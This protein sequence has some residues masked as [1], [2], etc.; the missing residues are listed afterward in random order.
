[1][2]NAAFEAAWDAWADTH[3]RPSLIV[4]GAT[5]I[6]R[7]HRYLAPEA[8][9]GDAGAVEAWAVACARLSWRSILLC[10]SRR[11]RV[12]L[13]SD[14]RESSRWHITSGGIES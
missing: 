8:I 7:A 6:G 13:D 1:M 2:D 5:P 12:R 3:V 4:A 11:S 9:S 14:G 10:A